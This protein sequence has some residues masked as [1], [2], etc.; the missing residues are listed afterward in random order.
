MQIPREDYWRKTDW[1]G[2][3]LGVR[4]FPELGVK[5]YGPQR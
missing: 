5:E 2:A 1:I 3:R 4:G